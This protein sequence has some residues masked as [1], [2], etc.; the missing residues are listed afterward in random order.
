ME[1]LNATANYRPD[2]LDVWIGTQNALLTLR[3]AATAPA[4]PPTRCSSTTAFLAADSAGGSFNDEMVQAI[5]VSKTIGKPVKLIWTREEDVRHDRFRPQAAIRFRAS[6][7]GGGAPTAIGDAETVVGSLLRSLGLNKVENGI[8]PMAVEGLAN[9]PYGI[10]STRV[11]CAL[12]NTHI[13]VSF[14]RSVGSSQKPSRSKA[15]STRWRTPPARTP[16]ASAA[17]CWRTG[18]I[19]SRSST[20]SP[21]RAGGTGNCR[22]NRAAASPFTNAMVPWSARSRGRGDERPGQGDARRRRARLRSRRQSADRAEQLE[23]GTIWGLSAA[24]YG[25]NTVKDGAIVK[26]NFDT[27]PVVRMADSPKIENH[28]ALTGGKKWAGSANPG[29]RRSPRQ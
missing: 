4:S 2:R 25:K 16:T 29:R 14:W 28:L 18:R 5:R 15:L 22:P 23:G 13:P 6:F 3:T 1:P 24:L 17:D 12:K 19:S 26:T 9:S 20:R 8:E 11:E 10:A 21:R 27:Y 7:D